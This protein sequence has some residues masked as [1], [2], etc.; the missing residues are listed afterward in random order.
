MADQ[1]VIEGILDM[2]D[3]ALGVP[4]PEIETDLLAEGVLD[5]LS[6]LDLLAEIE[7]TLGVVIDL[8][9][10]ELTDLESVKTLAELVERNR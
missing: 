9:A 4:R 8:A 5:S 1:S 10:L 6:L 2:F 3:G 7:S